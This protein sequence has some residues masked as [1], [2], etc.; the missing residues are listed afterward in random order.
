MGWP[1]RISSRNYFVGTVINLGFASYAGLP[2]IA[3]T[4]WLCY[5]VLSAALNHFFTV[6]A[7]NYLTETKIKHGMKTKTSKILFYLVFKGFFLLSGFAFL[8][9]YARDKVL[10]GLFIYIF[11]LIILG[12]SIKNIGMFFKKGS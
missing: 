2:R 5:L 3:T 11:Q 9:L 1:E 4:W 6:E 10:Q 12:L 8:L 7:L